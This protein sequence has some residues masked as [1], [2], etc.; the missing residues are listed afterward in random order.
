M[1]TLDKLPNLI[2]CD[3]AD[4]KIHKVCLR[5]IMIIK[6]V[7]KVMKARSYKH[8]SFTSLPK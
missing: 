7:V 2:N 3:C 5:G 4:K 8:I 1:Y 6:V